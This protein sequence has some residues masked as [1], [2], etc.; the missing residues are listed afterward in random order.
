MTIESDQ[1]KFEINKAQKDR[2]DNFFIQSSRGMMVLNAGAVI[3]ILGL[4]QALY[5]K[6]DVSN[7]KVFAVLSGFIYLVGAL[8][9]LWMLWSKYEYTDGRGAS[10][11]TGYLAKLGERGKGAFL[12]SAASFGLGTLVTLLGIACAIR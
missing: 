7:F 4:F 1:F 8:S 12:L 5:G 10:E 11:I 9:A 2:A 6:G 3:A